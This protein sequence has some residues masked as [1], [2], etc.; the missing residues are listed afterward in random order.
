MSIVFPRRE[1]EAHA[2]LDANP[3]ITSIHVIWTDICGVA[4]GKILRRDEL[5]PAW[6]DGRFMP[7]S[8]LVLDITGQD[9]PETGLVFDEGDRDMLLWPVLGSLVRSPWMEEPTAQYLA[10]VHDLDGT[11]HFADPRNALEAI[12]KR[13]QTELNID[14]KSVV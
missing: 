1:A 4:R 3:D 11:P 14:R 13:F 5:V 7:I 6:K 9:V 8:A 12:V 2:F 10:S